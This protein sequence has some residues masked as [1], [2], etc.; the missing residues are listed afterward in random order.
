MPSHSDCIPIWH[1][2]NV[3]IGVKPQASLY[4]SLGI[5]V[6]LVLKQK[7]HQLDI[8]I[9]TGHMKGS[10]TH[11]KSKKGEWVTSRASG[12]TKSHRELCINETAH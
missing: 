3:S 10:I 7:L 5:D 12:Y 4:L 9:M 11:L 6:C 2:R 8:S 1:L